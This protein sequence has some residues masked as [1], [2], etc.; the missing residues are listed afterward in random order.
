M[1]DTTDAHLIYARSGGGAGGGA[2]GGPDGRPPAFK[3]VGIS[4]AVGSGL[5]IGVSFVLK[6]VGLLKANVKYNED[7]GEGMGY[8]KVWWWWGGM[9]L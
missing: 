1:L 4:L 3:A 8:L 9:T 6:K 5:F 7:P 2:F